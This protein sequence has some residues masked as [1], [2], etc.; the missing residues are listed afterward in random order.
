MSVKVGLQFLSIPSDAVIEHGVRLL[1]GVPLV[2]Q[3]M[4]KVDLSGQSQIFGNR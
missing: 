3:V 4:R 2:T 1:E